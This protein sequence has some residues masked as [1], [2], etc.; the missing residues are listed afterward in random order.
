[1][2]RKPALKPGLHIH[3]SGGRKQH[4]ME[5]NRKLFVSSNWVLN[6]LNLTVVTVNYVILWVSDLK[7]TGVC[8]TIEMEYVYEFIWVQCYFSTGHITAKLPGGHDS[9]GSMVPGMYSSHSLPA[10]TT[11]MACKSRKCS[12][13]RT[14]SPLP[15]LMGPME[16]HISF[17]K[18]SRTKCVFNTNK[19]VIA[20]N[21]TE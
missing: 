11:K 13:S 21:V 15:P 17:A 20:V 19:K 12:L 8:S 9:W 7:I 10:V 4:N 1:M 5:G 16:G 2:Q 3:T 18:Q 14:Q 6:L